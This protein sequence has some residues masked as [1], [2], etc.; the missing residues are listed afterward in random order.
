MEDLA[1]VYSFPYK[2]FFEQK[3]MVYS[4]EG[5][6]EREAAYVLREAMELSIASLTLSGI[7]WKGIK[8]YVEEREGRDLG[9]TL[10]RIKLSDVAK[11]YREKKLSSVAESYA[12]RVAMEMH[13]ER[14]FPTSKEMEEEGISLEGEKWEDKEGIGFVIRFKGWV[15]IKKLSYADVE[16]YM[17]AGRAAGIQ[18]SITEKF[19]GFLGYSADKGRKSIKRLVEALSSLKGEGIERR[20]NTYKAFVE[21]GYYPYATLEMLAKAYPDLKPKK[22][23]GRVA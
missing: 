2:G 12:L 21:S 1:I 10:K 13:G 22:P 7:D 19:W 6:S 11:P 8:A 14:Y 4:L 18:D 15:V 3:S 17:V 5:R 9:E 16:D 23:R 20:F